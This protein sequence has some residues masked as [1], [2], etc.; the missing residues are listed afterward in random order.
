MKANDILS[1]IVENKRFEVDFQK[2]SIPQEDLQDRIATQRC[3]GISMRKALAESTCGIIAEFKRR[4]PSK[5]WIKQDARIED[6]IPAYEKAGAAAISILTDEKFFGGTLMDVRTARPLT[7]IPILRKD[8][9]ID[10]YQLYQAKIVGADAVLLI[11][12]VL[13]KEKCEELTEKAH[14]I[15]LEVLLEI[16]SESELAYI[17]PET[18][19]AGVN[20]RNLGSFYTTVDNSFRLAELLPANVLLVSESGI[21]SPDTVRQLRHHGFRGFLIGETWMKTANPGETLSTFIHSLNNSLL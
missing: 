9:I 1:T 8:F 4:S 14:R 21:D 6:I 11:A 16:H 5:G 12:A 10:E 15:G 3:G 17:T 20:N 18:D 2:R 13:E 19:M 7:G